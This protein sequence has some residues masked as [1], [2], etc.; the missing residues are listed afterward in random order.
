MA[1]SFGSESM[2]NWQENRL[3]HRFEN[4]RLW[5]AILLTF[6]TVLTIFGGI[7]RIAKVSGIIVPIMAIAYI[8]VAF[9]I[10][11][12]HLPAIPSL[13]RRTE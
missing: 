1:A 4:H 12:T 3:I 6:F 9:F 10:V 7:H 13:I 8:L 2:G 11:I 5:L